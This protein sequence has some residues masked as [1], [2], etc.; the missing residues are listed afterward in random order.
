MTAA[1]RGEGDPRAVAKDNRALVRLL[2][3]LSDSN[4]RVFVGRDDNDIPDCI[5]LIDTDEE[6]AHGATLQVVDTNEKVEH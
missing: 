5:W 1:T 4:L 3:L 2:A 6:P